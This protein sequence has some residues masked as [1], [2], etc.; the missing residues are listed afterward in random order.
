MKINN[1]NIDKTPKMSQKVTPKMKQ[2]NNDSIR[3]GTEITSNS[4]IEKSEIKTKKATINL[5]KAINRNVSR[6]KSIPIKKDVK[7]NLK[8]N[9]EI[10]GNKTQNTSGK[11]I[12][13]SKDKNLKESSLKN[14][15][16]NLYLLYN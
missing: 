2:S 9:N 3:T 5:G 10:L 15:D 16:V 7:S 12:S 14:S 8:K 6:E 11:R 4:L 13:T 1:E